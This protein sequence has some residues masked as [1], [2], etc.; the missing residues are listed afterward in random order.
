MTVQTILHYRILQQIGAGGMGEVYLA[1]DTRLERR[2]AL[3]ILPAQFTQSEDRLRRFV[4][5][6][7]T[8]SALNHPNII[9]IHEIGETDGTHY[10]ATEFITGETLRQRYRRN[11]PTLYEALDLAMQIAGALQAAHNAGIV[12]RDIKPDNIMLREDGLVKV[13]D[14]GLAKLVE[15][16]SFS[17]NSSETSAPTMIQ[18]HTAPGVVMGTASYMSPEQARGKPIDARSDIFSLGVVLYEMIAGCKPFRGDTPSDVIASILMKEPV[19]ITQVAPNVPAELNHIIGKALRKDRDERYQTVKSMLA[20]LKTL[21]QEMDF[22][23][24]LRRSSGFDQAFAMKTDIIQAAGGG[25]TQILDVKS[26]ANLAA[27]PTMSNAEYLLTRVKSHKVAVFT[28]LA[29]LIM[30]T[31]AAYFYFNRKPVLTSKDT[32]LL[33]DFINLTGDVVFDG[34]LKQGL[35]VQLGQSPFLNLF[36]EAQARQTLQLMGRSP[37]ARVTAEIGREIC[38]RQGLKALI[39]GSITP[40]GSHYV[41]ALEAINAQSGEAVAREQVE[42]E[43]KEQVLKS[44]GQAATSLREKLGESLSSIQN[45]D[46]PIEQAT[47]PSLEALKAYSLGLEQ[48]YKGNYAAAIPFYE[49][50]VAEDA[51]FALAYQGLAR[52]R[53][54][55]NFSELAAEAATKAFEL[56]ER[57]TENEKF[58]ISSFYYLSVHYDLHKAIEVSEL[59][60]RSYPHYWKPY[61]ALSDLYLSIGQ[62][63]RSAE[64]GR[65]AVRLNPDVAATYSNLAGALVS[66]ERHEE[67]KEIYR[68]A[69][70]RGFDAPEYHYYLFWI[71]LFDSDRAAMQREV[72]WFERSSSHSHFAPILK[73]L[74]A[75]F[76]G[77][78][79]E[80]LTQSDRAGEIAERRELKGELVWLAR[81]DGLRGAALGDCNIVKQKAAQVLSSSNR[82]EDLARAALA[83]ALCGD[84][85]QAQSLTTRMAQRYPKDTLLKGVWLPI[86]QAAVELQRGNHQQAIDALQTTLVYDGA[87]VGVWPFYLRG[88][89]YL[90]K[91]A[92]NEAATEF[93]KILDHQ[94]WTLS[95]WTPC[96]PLAHLWLGRASAMSGDTAKARKSYEEFLA[97]WKDGDADLGILQEARQEYEKLK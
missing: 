7:K 23:E 4:Q 41:I 45:F 49:R 29:V 31:V 85:A 16:S 32:I 25:A 33:T 58:Q 27:H 70:A 43:S 39:V 37:D 14:F 92:G 65:E 56:R 68:Q 17:A 95:T 77:R 46:A 10:I 93:Q 63:A 91:G 75:V 79:R 82:T 18:A 96:Y 19:P 76:Q 66:L 50:A 48:S 24:R 52:E 34:T 59:W 47:T 11:P 26:S 81:L 12:H 53:L 88:L 2:V 22:Q 67:A 90:R 62:Y 97:L 1:E 71:A 73:S 36:P 72:D 89:A 38:Q 21:K 60:K 74:E 8:A 54:N 69:M 15:Q 5:E 9:T 3:K 35:A 40:L 57:T 84:T 20:D 80:A 6:A 83:L 28:G 13:L 51:R 86:I 94:S 61:H 30:A 64:A 42:A 87:A 44:L 78:W 55:T